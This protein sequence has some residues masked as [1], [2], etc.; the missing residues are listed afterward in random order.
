MSGHLVIRTYTQLSAGAAA[1]RITLDAYP[2]DDDIEWVRLMARVIGGDAD[3]IEI[4]AQSSVTDYPMKSENVT[5]NGQSVN[6]TTA[7][8][9]SGDYKLYAEFTGT[10]AGEM[11]QLTAFG[12]LVH[13]E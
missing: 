6:V 10:A 4:G 7:M 3:L 2:H 11:L 1:Q 9:G 12:T 5:N 8:F 13:V